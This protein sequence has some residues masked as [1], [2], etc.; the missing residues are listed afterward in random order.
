MKI[1][2]LQKLIVLGVLVFSCV[3]CHA[4]AAADLT[5]RAIS[6][7]G[8]TYYVDAAGDMKD[9]WFLELSSAKKAKLPFG[10][11]DRKKLL[12]YFKNAPYA[13]SA[14]QGVFTNEP[15]SGLRIIPEDIRIVLDFSTR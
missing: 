3:F 2:G 11:I 5:V 13:I 6:P 9:N 14:I 1:K 8:T 4:D 15:G 12:C 10:K 7:S